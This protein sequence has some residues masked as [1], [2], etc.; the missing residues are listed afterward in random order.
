M[1]PAVAARGCCDMRFLKSGPLKYAVIALA[2]GLW[3][4]GLADQLGS[5]EMTARYLMLSA[6]IVAVIM[7]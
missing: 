3:L 7:I 2:A 6:A 4:V 5:L 1:A